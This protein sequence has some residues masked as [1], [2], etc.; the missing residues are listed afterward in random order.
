MK[1]NVTSVTGEKSDISLGTDVF[2]VAYNEA[3]LHEV[4]SSYRTNGRSGNSAQLSRS[5]VSGG[6]AKPW[7]QK[8]TGR[9][10]AGT[11]NSPIWR[12]GGVTFASSK[13]NYHKKINRKVYKL[14]LRIIF[15]E[16]I[17]KDR[18]LAI[19]E[20]KIA[21]KTKELL[22]VMNTL[23]L[24]NVLFVTDKFEQELYLAS[25][26][27]VKVNVIT[28]D[29]INPLILLQY[30]KICVTAKTVQLLEESLS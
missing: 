22:S 19:D 28:V 29:K 10:R 11:S 1:L 20:I 3:L 12:S 25:R 2:N 27:L 23:G 15:S 7:R 17:R 4:I 13:T 26:N 8:G 6:G 16:L 5:D 21:P 9:A 24:E 18:L 30:S 14:A